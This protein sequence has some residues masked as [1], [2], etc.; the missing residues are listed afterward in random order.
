MKKK[1]IYDVT[2]GNIDQR[3]NFLQNYFIFLKIFGHIIII[4]SGVRKM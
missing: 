3:F 2:G 1:M 4:E